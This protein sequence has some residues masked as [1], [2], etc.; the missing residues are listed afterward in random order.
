ML[1]FDDSY[2]AEEERDG[3]VISSMM[4]RVWAAQICVLEEIRRVCEMLHIPFFADWGTLL[5]AVR[6]HGFIPWDDDMDICMLRKDYMRFLEA[7]PE[8]LKPPFEIKSVYNDPTD[9]I[10]K[11]RIIN[12]RH[13]NFE[14][15]FLEQFYGCPYVVGIDIFPI[16]NI[17]ED[18]KQLEEQIRALRFVLRAAAS[19]P[20]E[21][22]YEENVLELLQQIEN[23]FG[24]SIDYNNRPAHEL[25]KLYDILCSWYMH[26]DTKEVT[27]MIDLANGWDY[28]A[29]RAWFSEIIEMPFE[30]T[31]IPVPVGYDGLLCIKYGK[32]YM[33]PRQVSS[34][35][36]PFF[37]E[38]MLG[39]KEVMEEEF[40]TQLSEEQM[41]QL[42]EMK[43]LGTDF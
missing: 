21:P 24:F 27:S 38:Q 40:Q 34:H 11:A 2:F 3:F 14:Q 26:E 20:E 6:H 36:Y 28:H 1:I 5:G 39:L 23:T 7:A 41:Y 19:V 17:T 4:K 13:M 43:A 32:D 37:K 29:K 15:D 25:K 10:I 12:G 18:Q 35:E 31:T 22:P 16:D 9:D 30:N 42:I 33:T 8:I